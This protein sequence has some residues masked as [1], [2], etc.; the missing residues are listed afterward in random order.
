MLVIYY[1][2]R[3]RRQSLIRGLTLVRKHMRKTAAM[4]AT[5]LREMI[6]NYE[7]NKLRICSLHRLSAAFI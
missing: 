1:E 7:D 2:A 6:R 5:V 3:Q 4:E